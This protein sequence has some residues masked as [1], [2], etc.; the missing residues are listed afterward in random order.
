MTKSEGDSSLI[1]LDDLFT[2]QEQREGARRENVVP[3][4]SEA[5]IVQALFVAEQSHRA[6]VAADAEQLRGTIGGR[7]RQ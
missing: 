2:T 4:R 6:L 1:T 5:D 7:T 3:V